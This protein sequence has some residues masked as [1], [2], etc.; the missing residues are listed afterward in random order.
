MIFLTV[1]TQLP[2]DRL[3]ELV[4][5]WCASRPELDIFGQVGA[6][7]YRPRHF[8]HTPFLSAAEARQYCEQ[9]ELIIGHVGIGSIFTAL[10]LGKPIL[11][12]PRLARHG[13]HRDDHQEQT[14][15]YFASIPGC[16]PFATVQELEAAV[17]YVRSTESTQTALPPFAPESTLNAVKR[18]LA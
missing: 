6:G 2:F 10:E 7:S 1:G 13:E 3:V 15:R 12:M 11:M 9:A 18:L 14:L 17:E 16:Y 5:R 4:D 8:S